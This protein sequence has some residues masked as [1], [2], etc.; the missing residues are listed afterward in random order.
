MLRPTKSTRTVAGI[1]RPRSAPDS[2]QPPRTSRSH[3]PD[4]PTR[5]CA[6][7]RLVTARAALSR[8]RRRRPMR[9]VRTRPGTG[10]PPGQK[11]RNPRRDTGYSSDRLARR[12][13]SQS[14]CRSGFERRSRFWDHLRNST[15]IVWRSVRLVS[16]R[17]RPSALGFLMSCFREPRKIGRLIDVYRIYPILLYIN[18]PR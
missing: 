15:P 14:G 13:G 7:V 10:T 16:G 2:F 8:S 17:V 11:V 9:F 1:W 4:I 6:R 18:K 5:I 12:P 3:R